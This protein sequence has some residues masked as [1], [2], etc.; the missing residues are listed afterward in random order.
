MEE[1]EDAANGEEDA[2]TLE[3][4]MHAHLVDSKGWGSNDLVGIKDGVGDDRIWE[5]Q[6]G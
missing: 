5:Q 4:D 3:E 6:P 2:H 1:Y